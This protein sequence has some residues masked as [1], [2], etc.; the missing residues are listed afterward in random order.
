VSSE[1]DPPGVVFDCVIFLQ[2]A[3]N[4]KGP[5][6]RALDLL[7]AGEIKLFVS[8]QILLEIRSAPTTPESDRNYAG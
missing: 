4:E 1:N 8:E 7:D 5:S 2:A 6:G 3:A